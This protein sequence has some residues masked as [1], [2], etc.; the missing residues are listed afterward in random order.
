MQMVIIVDAELANEVLSSRLCKKAE[1]EVTDSGSGIG[2]AAI[3]NFWSSDNA[4]VAPILLCAF[5]FTC[6]LKMALKRSGQ[7]AART[8]QSF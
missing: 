8:G 3:C 1:S 7:K 2:L 5:N 4:Q 6:A